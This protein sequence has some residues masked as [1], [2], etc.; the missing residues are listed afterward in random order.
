M[1]TW[2]ILYS[3]SDQTC[4]D[5]QC[6]IRLK[7]N[8]KFSPLSLPSI[9]KSYLLST[10]LNMAKLLLAMRAFLSICRSFCLT[11]VPVV[12]LP[13]SSLQFLSHPCKYRLKLAANKYYSYILKPLSWF[14]NGVKNS[15]D[16]FFLL[17]C[18]IFMNTLTI[19]ELWYKDKEN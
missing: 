10:S 15:L 9:N 19:I 17:K 1:E 6:L 14:A 2:W 12:P 7:H 11:P 4:S 13:L 8:L 5:W 18:Y 3:I 16:H